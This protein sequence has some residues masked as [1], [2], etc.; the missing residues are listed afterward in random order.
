MNPNRKI[1]TSR[2]INIFLVRTLFIA[3]FS[4]ILVPCSVAQKKIDVTSITGTAIVNDDITPR[5]AKNLALKEAKEEALRKAGIK[6]NISTT[7]M[8][9]TTQQKKK[10]KQNF[11]EISTVELNGAILNYTITDEKR[12]IDKFNNFKVALTIN[13]TVVKY[14]KKKDPSFEFKVTGINEYYKTGDT[15][16]F[17]FIPY[18]NGYLKI[19]LISNDT[20]QIIF[21]YIS[22]ANKQFS[23]VQNR[24]F[25]EDVPVQFPVLT[26]MRYTLTSY[27]NRE[28]NQ[29]IFVYTKN[30]IP[31]QKKI[32]TSNI[33]SWI[34]SIPPDQRVIQNY[35]FEIRK[36]N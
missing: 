31:F 20:S 19:F 32:T 5:Q 21:P 2:V 24:L 8:L 22:L 15:L 17:K 26:W 25:E 14:K 9:S 4:L 13:A 7:N 1:Y 36:S 12:S 16:S 29:L 28:F 10:V 18:K 30:N 6:E 33:H 3:F 23:D 11:V 27:K 34:Y 35:I